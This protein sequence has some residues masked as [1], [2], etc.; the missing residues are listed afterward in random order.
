MP[1]SLFLIFVE[2]LKKENH[3][4][5]NNHHKYRMHQKINPGRRSWILLESIVFFKRQR[6]RLWWYHCWG[7]CSQSNV[8]VHCT[9]KFRK[10]KEIWRVHRHSCCRHKGHLQTFSYRLQILGS[11]QIYSKL[12]IWLQSPHWTFLWGCQSLHWTFLWYCLLVL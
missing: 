7:A 2:F 10:E 8:Q 5:H 3:I 11:S 9:S 1:K 6:H 4:R 12:P